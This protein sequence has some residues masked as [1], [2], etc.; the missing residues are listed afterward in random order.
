M[1]GTTASQGRPAG[2][3]RDEK[4]RAV[5][6]HKF[7][8]AVMGNTKRRSL[9]E[10]EPVRGRQSKIIRRNTP[11]C[12]LLRKTETAGNSH[13]FLC[14]TVVVFFPGVD[15]S[16]SCRGQRRRGCIAGVSREGAYRVPEWQGRQYAAP[17]SNEGKGEG[18]EVRMSLTR[19]SQMNG[20]E[21]RDCQCHPSSRTKKNTI[22]CG[23]LSS[24]ALCRA[25]I[26]AVER[27]HCS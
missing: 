17:G 6:V 21:C 9:A 27:N 22:R 24:S 8:A 26:A 18:S 15:A 25:C 5:D 16:A 3:A 12:R 20:H 7:K 10:A 4:G 13:Q 11:C 2:L 23:P 1:A 14:I 19:A